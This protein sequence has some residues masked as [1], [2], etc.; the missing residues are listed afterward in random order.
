M[1]EPLDNESPFSPTGKNGIECIALDDIPVHLLPAFAVAIDLLEIS[2]FGCFVGSSWQLVE[3]CPESRYALANSHAIVWQQFACTDIALGKCVLQ[4][5]P[6]PRQEVASNAQA[7]R[8]VDQPQFFGD[9]TSHI[10]IVFVAHMPDEKGN[11]RF[12]VFFQLTA[13]SD[14]GLDVLSKGLTMIVLTRIGDLL[15][16]GLFPFLEIAPVRIFGQS[17]KNMIQ[18]IEDSR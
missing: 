13:I 6:A 14:E 16:G 12:N 5:A 17:I 2:F 11:S 3:L 18:A 8:S 1:N 9:I 4:F 15:E 10:S 7:S